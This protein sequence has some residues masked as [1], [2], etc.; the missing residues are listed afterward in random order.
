MCFNA[1]SQKFYLKDYVY[2]TLITTQIN[3]LRFPDDHHDHSTDAD[4]HG[5]HDASGD[6]ESLSLFISFFLS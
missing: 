1:L 6:H 2:D 4:D 3:K 5:D